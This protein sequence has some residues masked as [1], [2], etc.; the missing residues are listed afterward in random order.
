MM[1]VLTVIGFALLVIGIILMGVEMTVPGFGIPG[2]SGIISIVIGV[3]LAAN[4]L[5]EGLTII[6]IVVVVLG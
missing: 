2:I 3:W 4:S 6:T 1:E 5:K